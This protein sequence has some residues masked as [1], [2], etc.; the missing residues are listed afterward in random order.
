MVLVHDDLLATGGTINAA[1]NLVRQLHPRKVYV[2]TLVEL[3]ELSGRD[4][5]EGDVEVESILTL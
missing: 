2:N 5:I 3:K 4:A 1:C